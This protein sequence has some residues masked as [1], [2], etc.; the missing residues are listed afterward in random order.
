MDGTVTGY[1]VIEQKKPPD[2]VPKIA[3]KKNLPVSLSASTPIRISLSCRK[4]A[5]KSTPLPAQPSVRAPLLMPCKSRADFYK[6]FNAGATG[7]EE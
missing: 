7:Y 5:E 3:E 6:K 1:K 4:T 2:W